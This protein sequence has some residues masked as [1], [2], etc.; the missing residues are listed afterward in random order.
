MTLLHVIK[1]FNGTLLAFSNNVVKI[2]AVDGDM[3][4]QLLSNQKKPVIGIIVTLLINYVYKFYNYCT[5]ALMFL[6]FFF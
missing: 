3:A 1:V 6:M 4:E 2:F 5:L